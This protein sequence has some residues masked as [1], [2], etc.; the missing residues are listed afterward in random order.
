[1]ERNTQAR[2]VEK[3][4]KATKNSC[5]P[6]EIITIIE[7]LPITFWKIATLSGSLMTL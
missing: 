4:K 6:L 5:I 2:E 1:V 3:F 7:N